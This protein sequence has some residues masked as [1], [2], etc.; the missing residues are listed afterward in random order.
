MRKFVY[1]DGEIFS[2]PSRCTTVAVVH[3]FESAVSLNGRQTSEHMFATVRSLP[4]LA[5][6]VTL[7]LENRLAG[8]VSLLGWYMEPGLDV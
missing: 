1:S 3:K 5:G 2:S 7:K 8:Q 6:G 4:R